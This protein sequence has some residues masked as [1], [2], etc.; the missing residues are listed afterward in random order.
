VLVVAEEFDGA[1]DYGDDVL[2]QDAEV[3]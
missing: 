2:L 1:S 3:T